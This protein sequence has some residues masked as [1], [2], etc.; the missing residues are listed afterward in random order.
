MYFST[1]TKCLLEEGWTVANKIAT[2]NWNNKATAGK[3]IY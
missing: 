2:E 1:F 3:R